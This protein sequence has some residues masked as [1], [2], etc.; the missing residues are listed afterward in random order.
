ML[1]KQL[2]RILE[3]GDDYT[4]IYTLSD[5]TLNKIRYVGKSDNPTI[6]LNEHIRKAKYTHTHKNHWILSLLQNGHEPIIEIVDIVLKNEWGFWEQF[7]IEIFKSWGFNL[8]NIANGGCGGNLGELVNKKISKSLK[9]RCFSDET[10]NKMRISAKN[11]KIGDEGRKNLS[12]KRQ[13]IKNSMYGKI[14]PE[15]SKNYRKVIQMDL[16]GK[17]MKTWLGIIVA[18]KELKINRCTISDVCNGRKNT[19]GGFI[20]K[21]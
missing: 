6:R 17:E 21:Y 5:P 14:R 2:S 10:I 4:Y 9:N 18:S 8:T 19:A 11:R 12:I 20:W 1:K 7:W 16:S 3:E 15:S 13:G